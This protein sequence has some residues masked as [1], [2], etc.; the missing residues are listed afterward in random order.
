MFIWCVAITRHKITDSSL[1]LEILWDCTLAGRNSSATVHF[2]SNSYEDI[3]DY[4]DKFPTINLYWVSI[5]VCN[6][7][8]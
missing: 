6:D 2:S 8:F 1:N 3:K 4:P 7:I 5:A